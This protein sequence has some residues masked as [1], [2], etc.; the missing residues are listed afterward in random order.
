[1]AVAMNKPV[2]SQQAHVAVVGA[3]GYVG[4]QLLRL[5]AGHPAI[6]QLTAVS[7][8][9]A[10]QHV[11][12]THP[13]LVR[14]P[15]QNFVDSV[16][17]NG[18][19]DIVFFATPPAVAMHQAPHWLDQGCT[20]ID[21]SPDFRLRDLKQWEQWYNTKH[22][23]P[24]LV[25]QAVYALVEHNRA[26]LADAKLIAAPGCFATAVQL[27]TIPVVTAL[28]A[29]GNSDVTIIADCVSGTSGAGRRSDRPELLLAEAGSNYQAYALS[30]H[31]HVPEILQGL[32][33]C[34]IAQPALRFVPHLLPLPTGMFA[35]VHFVAQDAKLDYAATLRDSYANEPFIDVLDPDI[36]PQI[37]A[38]ANSNYCQLGYT[39]SLPTVMCA[40]DNLVKGAAGQAIQALN[41]AHGW[42]ETD[43]LI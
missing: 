2:S 11:A 28:A 36:S 21:C 34:G 22:S 40:L 33:G 12:R 32:A 35:T 16:D 25:N 10:G 5:L 31:R 15:K 7:A 42:C 38:V 27:A 41:V 8:R 30:G 37:S 6:A 26:A 20:V 43:G 29:Q 1:M 17:A 24:E 9:R 39:S 18:K 19:P 4:G 23:C 13:P 3:S 14:L